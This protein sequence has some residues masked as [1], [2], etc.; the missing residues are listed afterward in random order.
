MA[1]SKVPSG[2]SNKPRR[3]PATT[4]ETREL[5]LIALAVD[6]AE[7]QL[8]DGT[9]TSQI[10]VHFLKMATAQHE[11]E[12]EKL[13]QSVALDMAKVEQMS[14]TGRNEEL[15]D[16]ALKAFTSYRGV[17]AEDEEYYE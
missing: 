8:R 12:L 17:P 7:K 3:P 6:L 2:E 16:K 14:A 4:P 13:K 1:V 10:H 5:E 9:A 11:L 15:L